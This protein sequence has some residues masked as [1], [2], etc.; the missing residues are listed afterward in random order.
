MNAGRRRCA[1][2]DR[3]SAALGPVNL[4]LQGCEMRRG[5]LSRNLLDRAEAQDER[6]AER[7]QLRPAAIAPADLAR[8]YAV[9]A[10]AQGLVSVM[11]MGPLGA[12][13]RVA[14][15]CA[16]SCLVYGA[17]EKA[18]APG[19]LTCRELARELVRWGVR[20]K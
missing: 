4:G 8:L 18:T 11:G 20:N 16:G 5:S 10:Q 19:Q 13:S 9:P 14:L 3:S 1:A 7:G 6:F 15:P 2:F 17:L 12:V